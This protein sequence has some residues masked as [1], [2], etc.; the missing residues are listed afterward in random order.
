MTKGTK[1]GALHRLVFDTALASDEP[2]VINIGASAGV[3]VGKQLKRCAS[4][5][6]GRT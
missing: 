6:W 2:V 3:V 5:P 4:H 1:I